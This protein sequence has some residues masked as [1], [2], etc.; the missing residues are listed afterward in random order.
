MLDRAEYLGRIERFAG[1]LRARGLDGALLTTESN[2]AYFSGF[3]G[4]APWSTFARP[5]LLAISESEKISMFAL[6]S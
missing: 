1:L 2:I 3:R 6:I 5:N 4:H